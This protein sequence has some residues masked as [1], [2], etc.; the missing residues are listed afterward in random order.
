MEEALYHLHFQQEESHWWF[1][2]RSRIVRHV[3]SVLGGLRDGDT[4]LDVGCGTG[5]ILSHLAQRYRVVGIDMSPLAVEYSRRRGL[6][7][8]FLMPVQEFPR[9]R[10]KIRGVT[11]LDVIEHIV[12]DVE[13]LKAVHAILEPNGHVIITVPAHPWLWSSHDIANHHLR[14][15]TKR[16]LRE[17]LRLAGLEPVKLSYYNSILFPLG[18]IQKVLNRGASVEMVSEKLSQP[19]RIVNGLLRR[20]FAFERHL[21]TRVNLP[22]GISLIAVARR[23]DSEFTGQ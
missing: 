8:V 19:G 21:L 5:A 2:A 7:D 23:S 1:A 13:V 17:T 11:L 14:R 16:S 3:I 20:I 9:D 6:T 18:V 22:W 4:I 12:E 10:Y 15:Y